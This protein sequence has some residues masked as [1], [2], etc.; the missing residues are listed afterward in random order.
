MPGPGEGPRRPHRCGDYPSPSLSCLRLADGSCPSPAS[1]HGHKPV[2]QREWKFPLRCCAPP[3]PPE[4]PREAGG[5]ARL[6]AA[7]SWGRLRRSSVQGHFLRNLPVQL[8]RSRDSEGRVWPLV[9][10]PIPSAG[11]IWTSL[12]DRGRPDV[13]P[14]TCGLVAD[15]WS[16]LK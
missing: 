1:W 15:V 12:S 9:S 2:M 13:T 16:S 4:R 11:E 14:G 8:Q 7:A 3:A 5:L 6:L 10:L